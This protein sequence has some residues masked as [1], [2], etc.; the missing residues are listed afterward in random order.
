MAACGTAPAARNGS[1]AD[2]SSDASRPVIKAAYLGP[3]GGMA[4][5]WIA[6]DSG[7]FD[8][9]GV[10]VSVTNVAAD[11][12]IPGLLGGDF[13]VLQVS[14]PPVLTAGLQDPRIVFIAGTLKQMVF[15]M[16]V[17][18]DIAS[19]GDLKGKVVGTDKP[20]S[21]IAFGTNV[22]L[23][24]LGLKASDV[25]LVALGG[26][27]VLLPALQTHQI[28]AMVVAPP[29]AFNAEAAGFSTLVDT[30]DFPYQ[31]VGLVALRPKISSN[32]K[33]LMAFLQGYREGIRTFEND[34]AQS[35]AII[36]KYSN[37]DDTV[38]A[39]TYDFFKARGFSEDLSVS[40]E[41]LANVLRLLA[42]LNPAAT[43]A[44]P[45]QFVDLSLVARLPKS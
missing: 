30:F 11:A 31:S 1:P 24:K 7:G 3:S 39:Q 18:P 35:I 43:A 16:H 13:D 28:S 8:R 9:A 44:K 6:K 2:P 41:G 36:K 26:D 27:T 33:G 34:R 5:L 22:A 12:A 32:E 40:E 45:S 23:A 20:G 38:A 15:E 17:A 19:A 14:A 42:P 29:V 4:P 37:T 10:Q 25:Q 21:P